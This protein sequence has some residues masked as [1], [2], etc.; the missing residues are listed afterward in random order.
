MQSWDLIKAML[1]LHRAGNFEAAAQ[2]LHINPSTMR[3][4]IQALEQTI[5]ITLFA[6]RDS[7]LVLLE[8]HKAFLQSALDMEAA[9]GRFLQQSDLSRHGGVIRVT[10]LDIFAS[11][12]APDLARLRRERPDIQLELTTEPHFVDLDRDRIDLAIRM[13]RPLR[14]TNGLKRLA[15]LRF[16]LY[17][18]SDYFGTL[19][20]KERHSLLALYPHLGRMDHEF[21]LADE[22]WHAA[23]PAGQI[24]A[25]ADGYPTLLRMC[26]EGMGVAMLPALLANAS[27]RLRPLAGSTQTI[28]VG[29]WAV[30]RQDV[31]HLPKIRTLMAFLTEAFLAH[32]PALG[33]TI[34]PQQQA[35]E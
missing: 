24:V 34:P 35:A 10:T 3:R 11:L 18:S 7:Q 5:G 26:E 30:I 4:H 6:R 14:G 29:V 12:L 1:A 20:A 9:Y 28:E 22:Q 33:G 2:L 15:T 32:M 19:G 27:P 21:A 31:S 23:C 16:G 17:G 8:S 25:R 13:A